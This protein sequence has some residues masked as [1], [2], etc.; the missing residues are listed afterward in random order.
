MQKERCRFLRTKDM[1]IE[2]PRPDE[3]RGCPQP[4]PPVNFWCIRTLTEVGP[5][6]QLAG[7]RECRMPGRPCFARR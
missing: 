3:A 5:D 1:Y 7:T 6:D 4:P 2:A